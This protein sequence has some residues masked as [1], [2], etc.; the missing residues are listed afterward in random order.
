MKQHT[1][2]IAPATDQAGIPLNGCSQALLRSWPHEVVSAKGCFPLEE[3]PAS[4]I[5]IS[6]S[7]FTLDPIA[8]NAT[9]AYNHHSAKQCPC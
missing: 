2:R 6:E 9:D 3:P 5:Q 4:R 1:M 7:R 8:P